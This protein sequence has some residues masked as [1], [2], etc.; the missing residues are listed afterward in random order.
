MK[1][2]VEHK[3]CKYTMQI[4]GKDIYAALSF[5]EPKSHKIHTLNYTTRKATVSSIQS[6]F[7]SFITT[8][9]IS[10]IYTP[11]TTH[12]MTKVYGLFE[13]QRYDQKRGIFSQNKPIF[14][15]NTKCIVRKIND[16]MRKNNRLLDVLSFFKQAL[17]K[18][19]PYSPSAS[20][21][22]QPSRAPQ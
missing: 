14:R 1:F 20:I 13:K 16:V 17:N 11:C 7:I 9:Y 22:I 6:D 3:H 4:E 15:K 5:S 19:I 2:I 10:F 8:N 12:P 21:A 18:K